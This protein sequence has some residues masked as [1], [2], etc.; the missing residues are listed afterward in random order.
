MAGDGRFTEAEHRQILAAIAAAEQ[1]TSG[2]IRLFVEDVCGE[3]VLDRAAFVFHE[4][5]MDRTAE[6]NGVL[7]YLALE[8]RQFAIL[9]DAGIHSK[10]PEDFWHSI[11]LE[12]E[13]R[14]ALG[15]F[16]AGLATG[17]ERA[18]AALAEHFP[19]KHDDKNELSDE[20]VYGGKLKDRHQR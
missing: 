8:S 11:K 1:L 20:I 12:M 17:I 15:E 19:R 3:H 4:L 5:K 10:V 2:E 13:H 7:F 9:G 18:G 14:F 6:R 16:V